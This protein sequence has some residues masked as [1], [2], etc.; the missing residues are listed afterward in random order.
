M[1]KAMELEDIA[2]GAVNVPV[3]RVPSVAE[4]MPL[5]LK[6]GIRYEA[7][8]GR[9]ISLESL[10]VNKGSKV[11]LVAL[12]GAL[13]RAKVSLPMFERLTTF[14]QTKHSLMLFSD[15]TLRLS[16]DIDLAWYTGWEG[17]D[18]RPIIADWAMRAADAIGA[19]KIV[20]YGGSGGGFASLQI[21]AFSPGSIAIAVN[22]QTEIHGY[23]VEGIHMGP[24]RRYVRVVWP[25][26]APV[27]IA[28]LTDEHDWYSPL[29]ERVSAVQ[30]YS[31]PINNRVLYIQNRN[32]HSHMD[33]HYGPFKEA[34]IE[35]PNKGNIVF[36]YYD[37]PHAHVGPKHDIVKAA[38]D[39]AVSWT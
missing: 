3:V 39:R 5:G 9:G 22:P 16:D 27:P 15:P 11:L 28:N 35:G 31:R 8:L 19:E 10:L 17:M 2:Q 38:L 24:Q 25:E 13:T 26:L 37:G 14:G 20:F 1:I 21:S 23:K 12:H 30:T 36:D 33:R 34:A 6:G 18:I 29:G 32:D 4:F 7:P